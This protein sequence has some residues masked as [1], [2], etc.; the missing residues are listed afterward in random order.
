MSHVNLPKGQV[1]P[2][3]WRASGPIGGLPWRKPG[4]G[5]PTD[6][7]IR[8]FVR[9]KRIEMIGVRD[10]HVQRQSCALAAVLV[11]V[12]ASKTLQVVYCRC[13]RLGIR[14]RRLGRH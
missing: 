5:E 13:M 1:G 14:T 6:G 2:R 12:L 8:E 10:W 7:P 9:K 11:L 3:W 4:G